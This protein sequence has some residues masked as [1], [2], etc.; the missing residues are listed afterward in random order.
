MA[1]PRLSTGRFSQSGAYYVVTTVSFARKPLFVESPVAAAVIA[2]LE[3]AAQETSANSVAWVL[4][5]DHLHWLLELKNETLSRC[6]QRFK[7]RSAR[8]VN[9]LRG[10]SG[11]VW[12]PGFYDHHLRS[13]HDLVAQARYLIANPLR[14]GLVSRVE[15]YPYWGCRWMAGDGNL[16]L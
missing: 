8:A 2:E 7:S 1:S 5:P 15:E 6:L 11:A 14:A 16:I 9:A 4:M 3:R 13:E 12:Q 10:T